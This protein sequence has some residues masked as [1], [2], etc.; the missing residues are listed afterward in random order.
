MKIIQISA[1]YKPAVVYGGPTMS[2]SKLSEELWKNSIQIE[3]FTTLA[4]GKTELSFPAGQITWMDEVPVHFFKRLTKDHSHFS[5]ALLKHLFKTINQSKEPI[6]IHIHAWWNL[7]SMLACLIAQLK[8]VPVIL[9]PRGTLSSYSF[10]NNHPV[11]K[12]WIHLLAGKKLLSKCFFHA[13]SEQEKSDLLQ[14]FSPKLV[15]VVPNF[16]R[17]PA[18]SKQTFNHQSPV[19]KLLFL[20]RIEAIKRLEVLLEALDSVNFP[21]QLTIA[22]NG[23]AAYI[24][25]LEKIVAKRSM[26]PFVKWIG[27]QHH[28]VKFDVL[29]AHD[30][31]VLP[32]H[33]EN[34]GNVV[35]ESLSVGTAVLI[36]NQVGLADYIQAN[37]LG[38]T[39]DNQPEKLREALFKINNHRHRLDQIRLNAPKKVREDFADGQLVKQYIGLYREVLEKSYPR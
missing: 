16:I 14:L 24:R 6:I 8:K 4:N 30:L 13:T 18:I 20:S 2:V 11:F 9:S 27:F 32:S 26:Q 12:K 19:L 3:V 31:L 7:V 25:S 22:G 15:Q 37:N 10:N 36:S 29:Q 38:W 34:F 33:N 5:P 21:Y 23:E 17:L 39:F 35:I 1:S 28:D